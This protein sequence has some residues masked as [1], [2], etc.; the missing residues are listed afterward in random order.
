MGG[1]VPVSSL[2]QTLDDMLITLPS[3]LDVCLKYIKF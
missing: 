1:L 2:D 3:Y